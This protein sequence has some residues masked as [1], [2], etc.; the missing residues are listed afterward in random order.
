MESTLFR[1][2]GA[3]LE[4]RDGVAGVSFHVWAPNASAVSVVGDFNGWE[5]GTH[6]MHNRGDAGIWEL[7]VPGLAAGTLGTDSGR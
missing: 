4:T 7:F 6:R 2:L 5:G 3:H 1:H